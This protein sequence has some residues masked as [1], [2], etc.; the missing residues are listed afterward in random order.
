MPYSRVDIAYAYI[1]SVDINYNIV[2]TLDLGLLP[3]ISGLDTTNRLYRLYL[4][5][6]LAYIG[7]LNAL[8]RRIQVISTY[9]SA[10]RA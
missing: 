7:S 6:R 4:R 5:S 9:L 8:S 10:L 1:P 2:R 3:Y